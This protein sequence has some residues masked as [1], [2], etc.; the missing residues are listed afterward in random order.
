MKTLAILLFCALAVALHAA[1]ATITFN[2]NNPPNSV[3]YFAE[4]K[5]TDGSWREVAKGP[6]SPLTTVVP[7]S[8]GSY[9]F[10]VRARAGAQVTG[11]SNETSGDI[12]P[13]SPSNAAV[14]ITVAVT[15]EK[16]KDGT[17]V[18]SAT[19]STPNK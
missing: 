17:L 7:N 19:V 3:E 5:Q 10:R 1:T 13:N 9:T 8:P 16:K 18:A 14:V 4:Q 2:G 15:I 6:A 12:A 11:P